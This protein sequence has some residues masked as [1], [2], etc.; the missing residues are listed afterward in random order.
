MTPNRSCFSRVEPTLVA[1]QSYVRPL[2]AATTS[3]V[4]P[5]DTEPPCRRSTPRFAAVPP[6]VAFLA[7]LPWQVWAGIVAALCVG[8]LAGGL[9]A[10]HD[11]ERAFHLGQSPTLARVKGRV[12]RLRSLFARMRRDH[13]GRAPDVWGELRGLENDLLDLR[14]PARLSR[15][16]RLSGD[17]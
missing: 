4:R 1:S 15:R 11:A 3:G 16:S 5:R 7:N 13:D 14:P 9:W 12:D 10:W 2:G 17:V 6:F 8:A